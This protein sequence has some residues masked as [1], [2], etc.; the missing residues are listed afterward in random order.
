MFKLIS[1]WVPSVE[2]V[3]EVEDNIIPETLRDALELKGYRIDVGVGTYLREGSVEVQSDDVDRDFLERIEQVFWC[4]GWKLYRSRPSL[5]VM[6]ARV[7]IWW[8]DL[9]EESRRQSGLRECKRED[10]I[11]YHHTLGQDI[12]N[13]FNLWQYTWY[14]EI[15]EGVDM[16]EEHPDA[17]SQRVIEKVWEALQDVENEWEA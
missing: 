9:S 16:S 11:E 12:R 3:K 5:S 2:A 4:D 7:L 15:V 6:V 8:N 1:I 14:P 10:L 13:S 17:V